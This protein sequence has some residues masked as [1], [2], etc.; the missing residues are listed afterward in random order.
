MAFDCRKITVLTRDAHHRA[1]V[2][3][4]VPSED[5]VD[6]ADFAELVDLLAHAEDWDGDGEGIAFTVSGRD[7]VARPGDYL[8]IDVVK[9]RVQLWHIPRTKLRP[10]AT[11][12]A[13][14]SPDV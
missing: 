13:Y 14:V 5:S 6:N 2:A 3:F 9:G 12:A 1:S 10:L 7:Y 8:R 11:N 4:Q